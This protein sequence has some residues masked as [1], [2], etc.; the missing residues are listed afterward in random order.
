LGQNWPKEALGQLFS[1][2]EQRW[3]RPALVPASH[4]SLSSYR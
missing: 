3:K 2:T 1:L 4:R